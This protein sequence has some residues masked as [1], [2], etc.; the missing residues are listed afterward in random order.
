MAGMT[1]LSPFAQYG[2]MVVFFLVIAAIPTLWYF[3]GRDT[4]GTG[5][6]YQP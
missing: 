6:Y 2:L 4:Y 5:D 1:P 3:V